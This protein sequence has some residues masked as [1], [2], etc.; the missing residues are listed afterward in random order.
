MILYD[1]PD[2]FSPCDS[3]SYVNSDILLTAGNL[4]Q[5]R[6]CQRCIKRN[7]G[8]LCHDEP[9]DTPNRRSKGG[10][11]DAAAADD[12]V[13]PKNEFDGQPRLSIAP[14]VL[15]SNGQSFLRGG[16][17]DARPSTADSIS[18]SNSG[19]NNQPVAL[20]ET[21]SQRR[22]DSESKSLKEY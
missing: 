8:H 20:D 18:V 11:T 19:A 5:E 10:D 14:P 7:I 15:D 4:L 12:P 2:L 9:R 6:P 17:I 13:S 21:V 3:S 22:N 1:P 16:S